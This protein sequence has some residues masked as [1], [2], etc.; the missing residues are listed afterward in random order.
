MNK[1]VWQSWTPVYTRGGI[2][3][4]GGVNISCPPVLPASD[5]VNGT[6]NCK[7]KKEFLVQNV[8]TSR[9]LF[10]RV[11]APML[12]KKTLALEY[13]NKVMDLLH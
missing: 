3:Y 8:T 4:L 9:D 2:R 1:I 11:E 6:T 5:Q 7:K 10:L 13:K 12:F